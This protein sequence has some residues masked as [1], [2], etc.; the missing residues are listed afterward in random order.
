MRPKWKYNKSPFHLDLIF[1]LL[2]RTN[3][4]ELVNKGWER[5][6]PHGPGSK[7]WSLTHTWQNR[8]SSFLFLD[9]RR[10]NPV[11]GLSWR[12]WR[13]ISYH[14]IWITL[15]MERRRNLHRLVVFR[16]LVLATCCSPLVKNNLPI[17]GNSLTTYGE[18]VVVVDVSKF[19]C[20]KRNLEYAFHKYI[21]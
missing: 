14:I 4:F 12:F 15:E 6:P 8:T 10:T 18:L 13:C 5:L 1:V 19:F 21:N 7:C 9:Y 2:L 3:I 16:R 11:G 20:S 17:S